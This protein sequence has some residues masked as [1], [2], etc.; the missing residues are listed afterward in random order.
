MSVI[1]RKLGDITMANLNLFTHPATFRRMKP[2]FLN[3]WL[4]PYREYLA[5]RGFI[6]PAPDVEGPIDYE[7]LAAVF[8]EPDA[9][10][11]RD[12]MHSAALI[13]EM[14]NEDAMNALI[15]GARPRNILL[16]V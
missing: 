2:L 6:L 4:T 11:P 9:A 15:E 13:H 1:R 14:A 10:M 16:E 8:M 7:R 12:L 5:Q 3:R